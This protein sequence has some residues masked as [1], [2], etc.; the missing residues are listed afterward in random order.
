MDLDRKC[1]GIAIL[2]IGLNQKSSFTGNDT[3]DAGLYLVSSRNSNIP[4][5]GYAASIYSRGY[6]NGG[7]IGILLKRYEIDKKFDELIVVERYFIDVNE[8]LT[9]EDIDNGKIEKIIKTHE[10]V[11][12]EQIGKYEM[13]QNSY[14][15]ENS[16]YDHL[17]NKSCHAIDLIGEIPRRG[18]VVK[19]D[20]SSPLSKLLFYLKGRL[21]RYVKIRIL[22]GQL[23]K[24]YPYM[25]MSSKKCETKDFC[26]FCWL[27]TPGMEKVDYIKD[28][29]G[30]NGIGEVE[31]AFPPPFGSLRLDIKIK[32]SWLKKHRKLD[33]PN[34]SN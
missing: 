16:K 34:S 12:L 27:L 10:L 33:S 3:T 24:A 19:N 28:Y 6:G 5:I 9:Q 23:M 29:M 2:D 4:R 31:Y 15:F 26:R 18:E 21:N 32:K 17:N 11:P 30:K 20:D 8:E 22:P 25:E 13:Y 14:E 7:K 1:L